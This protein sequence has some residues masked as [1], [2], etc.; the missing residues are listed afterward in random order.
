MVG[1]GV[2]VGAGVLVGCG[3]GVWKA[4]AVGAGV[5]VGSGTGVEVGKGISVGD[6]LLPVF[7]TNRPG[8]QLASLP[9]DTVSDL[10]CHS[11]LLSSTQ[12]P[13][14]R[15]WPTEHSGVDTLE[16]EVA[17]Q[18]LTL[19]SYWKPAGHAPGPPGATQRVGSC[20]SCW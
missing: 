13:L 7:G 1:C 18:H 16:C 20:G 5:F 17:E 4:V 2:W 9:V 14:Y 6:G 19:L 10:G 8:M 15:C 12:A 11:P 3:V